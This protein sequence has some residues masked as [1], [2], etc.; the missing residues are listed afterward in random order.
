MKGLLVELRPHMIPLVELNIDELIDMSH[1][2]SIGNKYGDIY[3]SMLERAMG[4]RLNHEPKPEYWD[5]LVKP[6]MH[7]TKL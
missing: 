4:S 2:S 1:L 7:R 3:E 5:S 6:I